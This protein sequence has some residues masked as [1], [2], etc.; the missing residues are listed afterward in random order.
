MSHPL[1]YRRSDLR[2]GWVSQVAGH[3][4][5]QFQRVG[6]NPE[7]TESWESEAAQQKLRWGLGERSL[8]ASPAFEMFIKLEKHF[9][10]K[11]K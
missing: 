5:K 9:E 6:N 10:K 4:G 2:C 1:P 11:I 8:Q 7:E 3:K